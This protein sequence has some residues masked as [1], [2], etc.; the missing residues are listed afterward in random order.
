MQGIELEEPVRAAVSEEP[1]R[2]AVPEAA[3]RAAVSEE[4]E[5]AVVGR[6]GNLFGMFGPPA[7][8]WFSK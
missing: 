2:A 1:V 5:R 8:S 4:P 7:R 3:V 6:G